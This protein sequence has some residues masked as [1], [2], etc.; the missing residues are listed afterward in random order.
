[1]KFFKILSILYLTVISIALLIPLNHEVITQIVEKEKQPS[2]NISF[3]I[4]FI[5]FFILYILFY[6]AFTKKYKVLIFCICYA[7]LIEIL[8]IFFSRGF[9]VLDIIFNLIGIII[10][11][12]L[13]FYFYER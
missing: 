2:N 11:F 13:L 4:H 7:V 12:M 1:M 6:V 3:L 9:Q 10:S 5:L 8:Q